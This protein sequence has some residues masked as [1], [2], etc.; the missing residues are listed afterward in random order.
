MTWWHWNR[1]GCGEGVAGPD[2][3]PTGQ[4]VVSGMD[5][6]KLRTLARATG[7][8]LLLGLAAWIIAADGPQIVAQGAERLYLPLALGNRPAMTIVSRHT[9][10]T[11]GN[12]NSGENMISADGRYVAFSSAATNLV[13]GDTNGQTDIFVHD[14]QTGVTTL[15]SRR[16]DGLQGNGPSSDPGISGD[17]RFVAFVSYATNLVAGDTR[18]C[19]S[20]GGFDYN[21]GDVFVH[22][23]QTGQTTLVSRSSSGA[24]GDGESDQ[25]AIS[26]DGRFVAFR[27]LADNLDDGDGNTIYSDVFLH[28][29][30]T[31]QTT[32][33]SRHVDGT[34]ADH[35]SMEPTLSV[36]GRYVAY[37]SLAT[38]LVDDDGSR[39]GDMFVYDRQTG[40]TTLVSRRA[41]GIQGNGHSYLGAI[42]ADG[43]YVAFNSWADNLVGGDTN[44]V[45]D[46]LLRDLQ[47]GQL[48]RISRHTNGTQA[49]DHSSN[50]S[51]SADG[52]YIVYDSSAANLV[53]GNTPLCEDI[54]GAWFNCTDVFL[55]DRQTGQTTLI[56]R[57]PNGAH[58]NSNSFYSSISADGR[59]VAFFSRADN[60]IDGDSNG[61]TDVFVYDLA[62]TSP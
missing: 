15:V 59:Y 21:C 13:G 46:I 55:Y 9:N 43:R 17:G 35:L 41:D 48:M 45:P 11:L 29:R 5:A 7:R 37:G 36:D 61:K 62:R 44:G 56:S 38:T 2:R 22:D 1:W 58:G 42:S 10:G 54:P 23:R 33:L 8:A 16:S 39:W 25:P 51:L 31:R 27:S 53:D 26:G 49:D 52:R 12:N 47:T 19:L 60:L 30:Q 6:R 18:L 40:K 57:R 32:L 34:P 4:G 28:D 50:P 14:R 24:Y 3:G 20:P